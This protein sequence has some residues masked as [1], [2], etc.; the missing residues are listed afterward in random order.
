MF[1][2]DF[3][4]TIVAG[5]QAHPETILIALIAGLIGGYVLSRIRH[6]GT[7]DALKERITAKD[8]AIATKDK[9]I[10]VKDDV[11]KTY[12]AAQNA[13][14][15]VMGTD[16]HPRNDLKSLHNQVFNKRPVTQKEMQI[17]QL[18]DLISDELER[19][20]RE[21]IL[22]RRFR[23]VFNPKT[24]QNKV[25]T[26]LPDG[27]IGEGSNSNEAKWRIQNGRLEIYNGQDELYSRFILLGNLN[28]LHHTNDPDTKSIKGQYMTVEQ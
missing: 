25:L 27:K 16:A 10:V 24:G 20:L 18:N 9:A 6:Q 8:E 11:I 26:F 5:L 13:P 22:R 23:F 15:S 2:Q 17:E 19:Q 12:A 21:T 4:K 7:I 1:L 3:I 28:T 14:K